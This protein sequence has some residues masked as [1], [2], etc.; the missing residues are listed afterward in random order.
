M[1]ADAGAED[2]VKP[3]LSRESAALHDLSNSMWIGRLSVSLWLS[4]LGAVTLLSKVNPP[5]Q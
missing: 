1:G 3:V 4:L 5:P 2:I